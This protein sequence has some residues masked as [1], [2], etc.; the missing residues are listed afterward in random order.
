[1]IDVSIVV[2]NYNVKDL[3]IKCIKSIYRYRVT[4]FEVILVDNNSTDGSVEAV[5]EKFKD[6]IIIENKHNAGF[7]AANNQGFKM[8][9]GNYICML[10]PDTEIT[11]DAISGLFNYLNLNKDV[12]AVCPMLLNTDLSI[13]QSVWRFPNMGYIFCEMFY[14]HRI[15]GSK[16]YT[17]KDFNCSFE[18]DS[19]SGAAIM[20]RHELLHSVGML[21]EYLFWIEDV[22][23]CYRL[24]KAGY[25][26]MYFPQAK[27][28]HHSGQSAKKNYVVSISNMIFNKIKFY[29]VHH[30]EFKAFI[31]SLVS[32]VYCI[33][34]FIVFLV[35]SPFNV[36]YLRKARAYLYTIPRVF[37]PPSEIRI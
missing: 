6:V 11:D 28:I 12:A 21:N 13:Q 35:L 8:A 14:L 17:D 30:S 15:I 32:F 36:I 19:A 2:V 25:K 33:I 31:L 5:R 26:L 7:P 27:I 24:K 29:K 10:N 22:D 34:K 9:Q 16:F 1:M 23:F 18:A 3:L 37:N 4:G 20:F